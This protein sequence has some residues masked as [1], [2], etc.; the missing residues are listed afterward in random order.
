MNASGSFEV[1]LTPQD[2]AEVPAGR[3]L[4]DKTYQGDMVGSGTGQ[5]ISKRTDSG[6][7]VYFA[8]EEFSGSVKG[9]RGGFTLLHTGQMNPES[10]SL[11]VTI[12]EGSGSGE[13]R[14]ISGS[15]LIIQDESGHRYE[16][17][18]EL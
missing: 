11:E 15:M 17:T 3:M 12:L 14:S 6:T 9:H 8:I 4:I 1:R 7:A 18:F 10:Q 13:L 16:L 2:D 5:M